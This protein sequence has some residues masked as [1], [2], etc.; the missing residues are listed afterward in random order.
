[1]TDNNSSEV[2]TSTI[3]KATLL[4]LIIATAILFV[5]I[6]PAE[7]NKDPLG[8]GA[9]M[10]IKGMSGDDTANV[11]ALNTQT[12]NY[13]KDTFTFV[14]EPFE[15]IEYK[16]SLS[17][18]ATML[19]TWKASKPVT[20]DL[21]AEKEGVDPQEYSPS[22]DQRQSDSES[23]SYTAPF[24][25]VHG[26]FWE[27]RNL[28]AVTVELTTVGFYTKATEFGRNYENEKSFDESE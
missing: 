4:A 7:F 19:F 11:G 13:S 15:S 1:M 26:W 27:N 9:L 3:L 28:D 20:F 22:F 16:Y 12:I 17:E 23:G 6:L 14:L 24:P 10:G 5:F 8:T 25:G 21:H 18:G 2:K